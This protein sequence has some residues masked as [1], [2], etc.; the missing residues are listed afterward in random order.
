MCES[1]SMLFSIQDKPIRMRLFLNRK[2]QY[3]EHDRQVPK[4]NH[5]VTG[6]AAKLRRNPG[7]PPSWLPVQS[8]IPANCDVQHRKPWAQDRSMSTLAVDFDMVS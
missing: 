2:A 8:F 3:T 6:A 7:A 1:G 5:L 4:I